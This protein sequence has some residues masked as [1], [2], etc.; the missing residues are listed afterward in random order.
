MGFV[1]VL[2]L[3]IVAVCI[4]QISPVYAMSKV[5][6]GWWV[7]RREAHV[8]PLCDET[9]F[10]SAN[11]MSDRTDEGSGLRH[12]FS[13]SYY[14]AIISTRHLKEHEYTKELIWEA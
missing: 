3:H 1:R 10:R 6:R 7:G 9:Y 2:L 8:K 11:P 12:S 13:R 14:R 4:H 5:G